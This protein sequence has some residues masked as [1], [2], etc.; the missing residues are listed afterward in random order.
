MSYY[1]SQLICLVLL[2]IFQCSINDGT[3]FKAVSD[4]M[5]VIG[6]EP[7]EIQTVFKILAGILHL[8]SGRDI[9]SID[10]WATECRKVSKACYCV[11]FKDNQ[12]DHFERHNEKAAALKE[13]DI[14]LCTNAQRFFHNTV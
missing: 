1:C 8:V 6:F 9:M 2:L 12:E 5:K 10:L 4:A 7:E 14:G 11:D 13:G 3:E